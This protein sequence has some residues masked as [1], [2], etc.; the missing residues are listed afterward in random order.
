MDISMFFTKAS[1]TLIHNPY[2]FGI[3]YGVIASVAYS[4]KKRRQ[5]RVGLIWWHFGITISL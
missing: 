1:K 4:N 5:V 2:F 3:G